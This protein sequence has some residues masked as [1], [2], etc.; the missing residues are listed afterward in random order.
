M[1]WATRL[2]LW[3]KVLSLSLSLSLSLTHTHTHTDSLSLTHTR[4]CLRIQQWIE[5]LL[6]H[7]FS[8]SLSLSLSFSLANLLA[9]TAMDGVPFMSLPVLSMCVFVCVFVCVLASARVCMSLPVLPI[10]YMYACLSVFL[11]VWM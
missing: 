10:I 3:H 6:S 1:L 7:T 8:L 4:T 2:G 5:H 11:S 9:H